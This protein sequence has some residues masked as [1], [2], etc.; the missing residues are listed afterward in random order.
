MSVG[1]LAAGTTVGTA[2]PRADKKV[3]KVGDE[4][5]GAFKN[6]VKGD[7]GSDSAATR[8]IGKT[9]EEHGQR[10]GKASGGEAK[11]IWH[12]LGS[13]LGAHAATASETDEEMEGVASGDVAE[14]GAED[15]KTALSQVPATGDPAAA[16]TGN[17]QAADERTAPDE[18][19]A[20]GVNARQQGRG[21]DGEAVSAAAKTAD[22]PAGAK[23]VTPGANQGEAAA[24]LGH[25]PAGQQHGLQPPRSAMAEDAQGSSRVSAAE[26]DLPARQAGGEPAAEGDGGQREGRN[27]EQMAPNTGQAQNGNK[28]SGVTVVS[29]QVSPAMPAQPAAMSNT[30][31]AFVESLAGG[32]L[33]S[34]RAEAAGHVSFAPTVGKAGPVTTLNI[35]LQPAELGMV[36]ARL[37]GTEGQLSIEITVENAEARHR[38]TSDSDAIVTALRGLGIEVDRLT[39]Q[40]SQANAGNTPNGS[41]RENE[42][43]QSGDSRGERQDQARQGSERDHGRDRHG[44]QGNAQ[45][46]RGGGGVYI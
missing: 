27:R 40:Q 42:F 21:A 44:G 30:A 7:A 15:D 10:A 11:N 37:S 38:L 4:A 17:A 6:L 22:A 31:A 26:F 14:E 1:I 32:A 23:I 36:T 24:V 20:I 45:A 18:N 13:I 43:G 12:R 39:V 33:G 5:A 25:K 3:A 29:H 46:D 41:A 28:V 34:A 9:R 16:I 8:E 19:A 2:A 35:Q